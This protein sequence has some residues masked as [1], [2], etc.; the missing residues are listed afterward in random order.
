M[1]GS[2]AINVAF[3]QWM[4]ERLPKKSYSMKQPLPSVD[5]SPPL[6]ANLVHPASQ[7]ENEVWLG[8]RKGGKLVLTLLKCIRWTRIPN[9]RIVR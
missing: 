2:I 9:G 3:I 7:C 5:A 4:L 6:S 1:L 8:A